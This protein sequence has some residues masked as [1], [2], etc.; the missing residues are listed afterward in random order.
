MR[1]KSEERK[2][3][4]SQFRRDREAV[5][6]PGGRSCSGSESR[7]GVALIVVLGFLSIMVMMAVAFLT[8]AR[9]ERMVSDASLDAQRGRQLMRTALNAAMNDYSRHLAA[10]SLIMPVAVEDQ[11][12]LSI[13]PSG[14]FGIAG[15]EG[16]LAGS[17][18]ELLAG[19]V[20]DWIPRRYTNAP[21]N[22]LADVGD[23]Q[24]ILVRENPGQNNSRILGRYAYAIFDMSGGID[25][26]LIARVPDVANNDARV[27]SNRVRRSARQVPMGRLPEAVNA[28]QF[29]SYRAG[30]K[31]FDSLQML[32]KLAD[33]RAN[34]GNE[35][36]AT[37]W[38]PERKEIYGPGLASNLV[39]DL[40]PYSLSTFRGGRYFSGP[41]TWTPY[42]RVD[43][44]TTS[45][46]WQT[47]LGPIA[48]QFG[49]AVPSWINNAVADYVSASPTPIGVD[50][51]SPKNVPM[52][53]E[54]AGQLR[55]RS[56]LSTNPPLRDY[57]LDVQ[58][59]FEFWYP[60]P[61]TDN[62]GGTFTL[63]APTVGGDSNPTG[64]S[65]FWLRFALTGPSGFIMGAIGPPTVAPPPLSVPSTY[66]GGRPFTPGSTPHFTY[67]LPIVNPAGGPWAP[68]LSFLFQS[69]MTR[70]PI[71]L[72]LGGANADMIPA[73]LNILAGNTLA[74]GS[75]WV[76]FAI[77][78]TDPRLNHDAGQWAEENGG[79]GTLGQMNDSWGAD[80]Q[81]Q[82]LREGTNLYSRNGP[83]ETPAELG[84]ISVGRPWETIDLFRPEMVEVMATLV[85]D[86]NLYATWA[87]NGVFYTNG[88]INPNT[89]STN[90]L[91]TAFFDL[92]THEVPNL[93]TG[94]ASKPPINEEQAGLIAAQIASATSTGT[95]S[96]AFQAG[97]DWARIPA[98]Q[99]NGALWAAHGLNNNQRE[100]LLR[101]TW[102]L[103]GPGNSLFTVV[104]VAQAIKEGPNNVGIWNAADDLVVGERRMTAL[105]WRDP[106]KQPGNLHHEMFI[107]MVRQL[108]E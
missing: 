60:F 44:I 82:F 33:G 76:P 105:V 30:W 24:W 42:Q 25:A 21:Y 108:N 71:H 77:G 9:I 70:Q 83:M 23:A 73:D 52:F 29:K 80:V 100:S 26:N 10:N 103:F 55:F 39:S 51:P 13:P 46:L 91:A 102:G 96:S 89:R 101:N 59:N 32:I 90:V 81:A 41:N 11:F 85:A 1:Q 99:Q 65:Q 47:K 58:L 79:N 66:N 56:A 6:A 28:S 69:M 57:F 54:I 35:G 78:V 8:H 15:A 50:Y 36:S 12:Y 43:Q 53:N 95:I 84:F 107:R 49:G 20:L 27:Q 64:P 22:A 93:A 31:G 68:G 38:Q 97:T 18:V 67:E 34:D 2:V 98:M 3:F 7:N 14:A 17:G 19:E 61:S 16:T 45:N 62:A 86:T 75:P 106:F 92:A 87:T 48:S 5:A 94:Q 104:V 63:D 37:R 4:W 40:T 72:A 88:T 74:D